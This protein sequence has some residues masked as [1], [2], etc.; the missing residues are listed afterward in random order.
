[1]GLK[2][3]TRY[4]YL[5]TPQVIFIIDMDEFRCTDFYTCRHVGDFYFSKKRAI[6]Y[7]SPLYERDFYDFYKR[8]NSKF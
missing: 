5:R 6:S 8:S 7:Q 2:V 1:M 4:L 3:P